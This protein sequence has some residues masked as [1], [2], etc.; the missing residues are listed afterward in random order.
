MKLE[1]CIKIKSVLESVQIFVICGLQEALTSFCRRL[2]QNINE[3]FL[4]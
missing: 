3:I 1:N 2:V 4:N